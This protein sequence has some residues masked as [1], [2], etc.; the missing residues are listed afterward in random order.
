MRIPVVKTKFY[1]QDLNLTKIQRKK[2]TNLEKYKN[3][4]RFSSRFTYVYIISTT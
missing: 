1:R 4:I 3:K 2:I